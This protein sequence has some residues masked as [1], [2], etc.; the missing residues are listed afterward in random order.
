MACFTIIY[1]FM[2]RLLHLDGYSKQIYAVI[3]GFWIRIRKP[4]YVPYSVIRMITGATDPTISGSIK[5]LKEEGLITSDPK[6]GIRAKYSIV[7]TEEIWA[8]YLRDS[9]HKGVI[10]ES[11]ELKD[12]KSTT[13][14]PR[15]S[16]KLPKVHKERKER[17]KKD[18]SPISNPDIP[19]AGS[20][21]SRVR[22]FK[23]KAP[24]K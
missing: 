22:I 10:N 17:Q 5:R 23:I 4:V 2:A 16:T 21:A 3:F 15:E 24:L 14:V 20:V 7:M 9:D 12:V 11:E 13:K 6:P 8:A 1:G 19:S 18:N